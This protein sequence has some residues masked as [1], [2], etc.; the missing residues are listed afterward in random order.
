LSALSLILI[1]LN[2]SPHGK[3]IYPIGAR[4]DDDEKDT[5][6]R[7]SIC[8]FLIYICLASQLMKFR[9]GCYLKEM[10]VT[11]EQLHQSHVS[12]VAIRGV[13][14]FSLAASVTLHSG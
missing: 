7:E 14:F 5:G 13:Y 4:N 12:A 8:Y 11:R 9:I 1:R 10:R 2:V 6:V 3:Q